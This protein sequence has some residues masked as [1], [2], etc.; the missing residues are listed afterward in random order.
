MTTISNKEKTKNLSKEKGAIFSIDTLIGFTLT[1][2]ILLS[3]VQLTTNVFM[4]QK[5][6]I[7]QFYL[8]EKTIMIADSLIKNR[9][10]KNPLLGACII[11]NDKKRVK[12]NEIE[13]ELLLQAKKFEL[14]E[15]FVKEL[16][17]EKNKTTKIILLNNK[18]SNNCILV[19]RFALINNEKAIITIQGCLVE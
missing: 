8:E 12:S 10:E 4:Q 1:L 18:N 3:F 2:L 19:K 6:N 16:T 15:F 17:W 13:E 7:K 9:N 5:Q 14:K 11:D